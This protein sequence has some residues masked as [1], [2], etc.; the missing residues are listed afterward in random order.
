M[1][2]EIILYIIIATWIGAFGALFLKKG[3]NFKFKE[4][5]KNYTLFFGLLLYGLSSILFI[6]TLRFGELSIIY[7]L[8]SLSYVWVI[9]LSIWFL[10]EKITKRK[11]LGIIFIIIGVI[12]LGLR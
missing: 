5:Y 4:F 2:F 12:L 1:K 6:Y 3:S 11:W 7:P 10:K 9:C 8:T